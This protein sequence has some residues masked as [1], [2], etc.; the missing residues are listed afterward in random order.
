M[1]EMSYCSLD[2]KLFF[3]FPP[4]VTSINEVSHSGLFLN[5]QTN[6]R[7]ISKSP[8]TLSQLNS[9]LRSDQ[10][11]FLDG[12]NTNSVRKGGGTPARDW[13]LT[14]TTE[15]PLTMERK[16]GYLNKFIKD[17]TL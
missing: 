13:P 16:A 10:P 17:I 15:F 12:S 7:P 3:F 6:A 8:P 11:Q 2:N 9:L 4:W 14:E 5:S 1:K